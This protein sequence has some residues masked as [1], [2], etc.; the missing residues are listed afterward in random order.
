MFLKDVGKDMT[1]GREQKGGGIRADNDLPLQFHE[2]AIY[3]IYP[4]TLASGVPSIAMLL[5]L[6]TCN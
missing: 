1:C 2:F 3:D 4:L 5:A 6:V